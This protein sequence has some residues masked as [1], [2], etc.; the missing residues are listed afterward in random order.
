MRA[1]GNRFRPPSWRGYEQ[2]WREHEIVTWL[3]PCAHEAPTMKLWSFDVRSGKLIQAG[4]RRHP[5][6]PMMG[7]AF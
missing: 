3:V 6:T 2:A 7:L 1:V 5:V 4:F